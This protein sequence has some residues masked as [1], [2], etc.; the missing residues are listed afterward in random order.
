MKKEEEHVKFREP[1]LEAI[2]ERCLRKGVFDRLKK[3]HMKAG[4]D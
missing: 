3:A 4:L 1:E 2:Y